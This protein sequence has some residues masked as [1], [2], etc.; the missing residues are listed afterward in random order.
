MGGVEAFLG[1]LIK[2]FLLLLD[3]VFLSVFEE[4]VGEVEFD[5]LNLAFLCFLQY[6]SFFIILGKTKF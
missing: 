2:H 5:V 1:L 4:I 6:L 3:C